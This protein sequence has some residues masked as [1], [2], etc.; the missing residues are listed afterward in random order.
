MIDV[1]CHLQFK[2]FNDDREAVIQQ[3]KEAG[4]TKIIN[5]GTQIS[6]SEEA[7]ALA[8]TYDWMW[9]IV[10]IHPHHADK[11]NNGWEEQLKEL[12]QHDRVVG[13]GEIGL[14]YFSYQSNGIV[15][16]KIQKDTFEKQLQVA[17][18]N[19]KPLQ[20]HNRHAGKDILEILTHHK[21]IL[22]TVPGMFHC[23]AGNK[24]ILIKALE[25]GF[26]IGF[27]GN[28]TYKGLAPGED[29]LL[30]DLISWT[31]LDRIVLETD[32]P[33]LTPVPLRGTRNVPANVILVGE[34]VAKMK[35]IS[36]LEIEAQTDANVSVLFGI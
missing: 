24:D 17:Y 7:I 4:I 18:E 16:P 33:Y 35:G 21:N 28:S 29:T 9:A 6:S 8:E 19:G 5:T 3:A 10:G 11:L 27:D 12:A 15:D 2:G 13:I 1:H 26:Y 14:D 34:F 30:S 36:V 25:L 31:P 23:F 20:I 32:S 22:R